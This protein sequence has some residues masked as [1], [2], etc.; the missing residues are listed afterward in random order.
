MTSRRPSFFIFGPERSATTLLAFLLSGQDGVFVLND[1]FVFDQYVE[2]ALLRG[3]GHRRSR[4]GRA[5]RLGPRL[6]PAV[7]VGSLSNVRSWRRIYHTARSRYAMRFQPDQVVSPGEIDAYYSVLAG[8]YEASLR[9]GRFSFLNTYLAGLESPQSPLSL[10]DLFGATILSISRLFAPSFD[11]LFG[12]KT[13]IHMLYAEWIMTLYPHAK[14]ILIV[15]EPLANVAS[16][17]RRNGDFR[18]ALRSY[19][20][21]A[22][23]SISL[24]DHHRVLT[25]RHED[26]VSSTPQTLGRVM[27]FIDPD[28]H[29]DD[30]CPINAYTKTGYT[31]H[32]IDP[33][34]AQMA[35][36]I[37]SLRQQHEVA[38]RF[39]RMTER[40]YG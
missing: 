28:L 16:I 30:A 18:R 14:A 23:K 15:R 31:G 36:E 6:A 40:F 29:L 25:I 35:P 27:Q 3:R 1:S 24:S 11:G 34:R 22:E 7:K 13:P 17:V 33:A 12:E 5:L 32:S 39:R 21:F 10:S 26:L 2:W 19:E 38:H 9:D 4:A 8:R 20:M 37:L